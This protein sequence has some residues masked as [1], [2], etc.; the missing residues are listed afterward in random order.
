[1]AEVKRSTRKTMVT[2]MGNESQHS[3]WGGR[4]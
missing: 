3:H 2:Q 1:M 4:Y